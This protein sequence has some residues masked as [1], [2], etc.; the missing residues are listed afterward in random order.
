MSQPYVG[1]IRMFAGNF[2]PAGWMLCQGQVLTISEYTT[3]YQLIGTTYGGNGQTTFQLPDLRSRVPIHMGT[4]GGGTYALGSTGGA[5]TVTLTIPQIPAHNHSYRASIT[6]GNANSPQ[7]NLAANSTVATAYYDSSAK[8][9]MGANSIGNTGG[10]EPH[11]NIQPFLSINFI[12]AL[13][14]VFPSQ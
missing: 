11:S 5:E 7:N 3:L 13:L 14:G 12:I 10:S 6:A 8:T 1:E 4:G 9:A 2:A